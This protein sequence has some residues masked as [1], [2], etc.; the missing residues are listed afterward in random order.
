MS[1]TTRHTHNQLQSNMNNNGNSILFIHNTVQYYA[2]LDVIEDPKKIL[3]YGKDLLHEV[4]IIGENAS[5][6]VLNIEPAN[7]L[8]IC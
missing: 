7:F 5:I 2:L 1:D 4:K 3:S 6:E 8:G